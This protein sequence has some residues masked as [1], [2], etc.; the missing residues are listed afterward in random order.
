M[1]IHAFTGGA[2]CGKTHQLM[3]RL[4]EHLLEHPLG[5]G[6]KVLALTFMH[7]SRR[8]LD[9][10]LASAAIPNRAYECATID[11]FAWRIAHRWQS[12]LGAL[13]IDAPAVGDYA[14][15]CAAAAALLGQ[16]GVAGWVARCYPVII[17]DEAQNL[18]QDRL[19]ILTTLAPHVCLFAAADEFQCYR[20]VQG[21]RSAPRVFLITSW[22]RYSVR[23]QWRR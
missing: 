7:G 1:S 11:F 10:R 8:R 6:Q 9:E 18:N 4:D 15:I 3:A 13:G 23:F 17:L 2:G 14:G 21:A 22:P 12:L 19:A 16:E 20:P 5:E